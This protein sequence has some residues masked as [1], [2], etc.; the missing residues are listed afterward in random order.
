MG[1]LSGAKCTKTRYLIQVPRDPDERQAVMD[2]IHGRRR[3]RAGAPACPGPRA[4]TGA[5]CATGTRRVSMPTPRA[6]AARA[7]AHGRPAAFCPPSAV[8][9]TAPP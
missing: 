3:C 6:L 5:T 1:H 4:S 7:P 9:Y 2:E 8:C